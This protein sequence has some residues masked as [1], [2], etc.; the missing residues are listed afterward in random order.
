MGSDFGFINELL[1]NRELFEAS[2]VR[3]RLQQ[4]GSRLPNQLKNQVKRTERTMIVCWFL[5]PAVK[6]RGRRLVLTSLSQQHC[7]VRLSGDRNCGVLQ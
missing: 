2:K 7:H 6:I 5:D 3:G 1:K 4:A